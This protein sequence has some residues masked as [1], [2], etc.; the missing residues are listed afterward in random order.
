MRLPSSAFRGRSG[1]QTDSAARHSAYLLDYLQKAGFVSTAAALLADA[2]SIPT[3][4]HSSGRSFALPSSASS[5]QPRS[6]VSSSFPL[7]AQQLPLF[8]SPSALSPP[9]LAHGGPSQ[10]E[11]ESPRRRGEGSPV[12]PLSSQGG[13]DA[14]GK[15]NADTVASTASAASTTSHFGFEALDPGHGDGRAADG[16]SA[17]PAKEGPRS[18]SKRPAPAAHP[19]RNVSGSSPNGAASEP[20]RVPAANVQI[21]APTGFLFE[22]WSVFWDVFR[23]QAASRRPGAVE[24]GANARSFCQAS[25]AAVDAAMQRQASSM[26][27]AGPAHGHGHVHGHVPNF[28]GVTAAPPPPQVM[29]PPPNMQAQHQGPPPDLSLAAPPPNAHGGPAGRQPIPLRTTPLP[30]RQP[31]H[32]HPALA[33]QGPPP[34]LPPQHQRAPSAQLSSRV[35][36]R[37]GA[38]PCVPRAPPRLPSNTD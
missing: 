8:N 23:A 20:R 35:T 32:G 29:R 18:P 13:D 6:A 33:Q 15:N 17:S 16:A 28:V 34:G 4:P 14:Y 1:Q 25:S 19:L 7:N 11:H 38:I 24:N 12:S 36:G 2:P 10:N 37:R 22:W 31:P 5:S 3:H 21:D 27:R 26:L 9:P 30:G